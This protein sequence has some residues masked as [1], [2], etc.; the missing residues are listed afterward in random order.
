[1]QGSILIN[2]RQHTVFINIKINT[3]Y[4]LY[5]LKEQYNSMTFMYCCTPRLCEAQGNAA[6][7]LYEI[8][9]IYI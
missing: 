5:L 6:L 9:F 4:T 2:K 7:T 8:F 1:M 3:F